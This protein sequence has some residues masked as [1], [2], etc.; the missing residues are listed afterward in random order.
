MR[1]PRIV[2]TAVQSPFLSGGAEKHVLRLVEEL[3]RRN[4]DTETVT[5]PLFERRHPDLLKSALLWRLGDFTHFGG[6]PVDALI[7]TRFPTYLAAHPRKV[8]WLIHQYRQVYDQ[9]GTAY[10]DYTGSEEDRRI[11]ETVF[12]MDTTALSEARR[13]FANS[14]NVAARLK[15]F[16]GLQSQP[17][18]HPPPL[19]G[20]YRT[21]PIGDYALWIGRLEKWKRPDLAIAAVAGCPAAKLRIVGDGPEREAMERYAKE[22]SVRERCEFLG[23]VSDESLLDELAGAR[24]VLVTA[25]DEDLGYVPL[26]AYL[27]GKCVLAVSDGGGPLEFVSDGETGFVAD[28]TVESMGRT[29]LLAW[30]R[31]DELSVMA[32]RGR[33]VVER[34]SWDDVVDSLLSAS[35]IR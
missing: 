7:G 19:A 28:P 32:A 9:F 20:R 22:L 1:R 21:G 18:Y 33:Q 25:A 2:V 12:A 24:I 31:V 26:E 14:K 34:I 27:S 11:R 8:V 23:N 13:I 15:R 10:S 16:N 3:R 4:V 30:D 17:L 6:Y 29:L 5:M 35:E